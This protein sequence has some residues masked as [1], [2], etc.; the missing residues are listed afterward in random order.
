M[1]LLIIKKIFFDST[2]PLKNIK[3]VMKLNKQINVQILYASRNGDDD[4]CKNQ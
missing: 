2:V 1:T 4:M 3:S